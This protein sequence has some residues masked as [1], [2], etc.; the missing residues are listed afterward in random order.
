[1]DLRAT[2]IDAGPTT[3]GRVCV[4]VWCEGGDCAETYLDIDDAK[5]WR[6]CLDR[7]ITGALRNQPDNAPVTRLSGPLDGYQSEDSP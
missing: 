7:A 3:S 6:D 2:H 4:Y 1:M 5:R